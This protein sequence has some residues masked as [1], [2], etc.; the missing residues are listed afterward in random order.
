[1]NLYE[2]IKKNLN[3]TE[4]LTEKVN[5]DNDDINENDIEAVDTI[6]NDT[7]NTVVVDN[8]SNESESE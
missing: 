1:M 2:N 5:H 8:T 7:E 4:I 3:E 6:N